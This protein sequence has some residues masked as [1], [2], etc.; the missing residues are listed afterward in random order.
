MNNILKE[1]DKDGKIY[2]NCIKNNLINLYLSVTGLYGY[3]I[4][5]YIYNQLKEKEKEEK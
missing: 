2:K 4:S 1:F 5:S 3:Y